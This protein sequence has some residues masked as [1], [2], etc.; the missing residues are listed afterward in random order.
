MP[1]LIPMPYYY[2]KSIE[3][4]SRE[5][6]GSNGQIYTVRHGFNTKTPYQYDW[7]CDCPSFKYREGYCKHIKAVQEENNYCGWDQFLEGEKP[8]I[9]TEERMDG[10]VLSKEYLCPECRGEAKIRMVA[11]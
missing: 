4:F 7:S 8:I 6:E 10:E 11:V 5:V 2:C 9:I 1:D 3:N